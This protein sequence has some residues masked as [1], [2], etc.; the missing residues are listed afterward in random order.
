M[1]KTMCHKKNSLTDNIRCFLARLRTLK[2]SP[3]T[4]DTYGRALEDFAGMLS[5]HGVSGVLHI[6]RSQIDQYRLGLIER[7]FAAGS[8]EVFLRAVRRFFGFLEQEQIIFLNPTEGMVSQQA[9]RRLVPAPSEEQVARLLAQPDV[10]KPLGIRDRAFLET[11]Y[12]TGGRRAELMGIATRDVDLRN[13]TI[14]LMGKGSRERVVP[15]GNQAAGWL[16]KYVSEVRP[17]LMQGTDSPALWVGYNG[18]ALGYGWFPS[19]LYKYQKSNGSVRIAPHDFRRACATHMLNHGAAAVDI[20]ML[21]GH[22]S[23][24]HLSQYLQLSISE[25]KRAHQHTNPGH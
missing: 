6:G 9:P 10:S 8:T 20:Q 18:H 5:Q 12:S 14:R 24:R 11:A 21:L 1:K 22:T 7:G 2:Y 19:I 17:I 15:I 4:I 3:K 25:L 16:G 13:G 23:L